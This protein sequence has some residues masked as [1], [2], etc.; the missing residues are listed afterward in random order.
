MTVATESEGVGHLDG[1]SCILILF[2]TWLKI[3][4]FRLNVLFDLYEYHATLHVKGGH[5]KILVVLC[6]KSGTP[7]PFRTFRTLKF[8]SQ[9]FEA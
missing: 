5:R 1:N 6:P 2:V 8:K 7:P 9:T 4:A 3:H